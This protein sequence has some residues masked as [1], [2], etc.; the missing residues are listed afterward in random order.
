[1]KRAQISGQ[2]FIYILAIIIAG[3]IIL[4][5]YRA[6]DDLIKR[7]RD[8]ALINF[9]TE[10]IGDIEKVAGSYGELKTQTYV[11]P[12]G[13]TEICFVDFNIKPT[14]IGKPEYNLINGVIQSGAEQNIFLIPP[15]KIP[16]YAEH[17]EVSGPDYYLCIS[18]RQGRVRLILEGF[19]N[20]TVVKDAWG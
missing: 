15:A 4:Y 18:G 7:Q 13:T 9:K 17:L 14:L 2:I 1:M 20:R 19:G 6:V 11:L 16:L 5:G 8:V 10:L 3:L 12:P